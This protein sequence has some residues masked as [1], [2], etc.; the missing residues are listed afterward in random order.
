LYILRIILF[1][2][3]L[4]LSA[5]L[6]SFASFLALP[7]LFKFERRYKFIIGNWCAFVIWLAKVLLGINY[8]I[9]GVQNLPQKPYVIAANHQ[10][11][12]ETFFLSAIFCPLTQVLKRELLFVPF[13]GWAMALLKPIAID[14]NNPKKAL[15]QVNLGAQK[16]LQEGRFV[17]IFPEG[18]RMPPN[19][20]GSF[21]RSGSQIAAANNVPLVPIYHN[22]GNFWPKNGWRKKAGTIQIIIGEPLIAAGKDKIAITNLNQQLATWMISEQTKNMGIKNN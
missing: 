14:R 5:C 6:W 12:W 17:L 10:S 22:A 7:F 15:K 20:L 4:G 2:L 19:N 9:I 8:Q 1:Y 21:S 16:A 3:G 18:T 13:F 11:T